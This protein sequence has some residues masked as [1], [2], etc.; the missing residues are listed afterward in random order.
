MYLKE[1]TIFIIIGIII[2]CIIFIMY[3]LVNDRDL[4]KAIC[5]LEPDNPIYRHVK[6][7]IHFDEMLNGNVHVH[8]YISNLSP[9]KHGFHV[10][11]KG[12]R[13]KG[14]HT[15]KG[16]YN[17]FNTVHGGLNS[18]KRHVGDLGN[19]IAD[20]TGMGKV[21]FV[22]SV[23]KLTGPYSIIGRGLVVHADED[24]LTSNPTGNSGDRVACGIIGIN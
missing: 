19:I 1:S 18:N 4:K 17:P 13:V 14:C 16:H 2:I 6:G 23:I 12:N 22:D 8:G 11:E 20:E 21:D 9:G 3:R 24:D 10:H 7:V 15:M 5:V